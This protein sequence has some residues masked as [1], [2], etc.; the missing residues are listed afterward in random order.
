MN[1][2]SKSGKNNSVINDRFV[3]GSGVI[4]DGSVRMPDWFRLWA[5]EVREVA[6]V[7]SYRRGFQTV[8][9]GDRWW[10][11]M[12]LEYRDFLLLRD[13]G[14]IGELRQLLE[15]WDSVGVHLESFEDFTFRVAYAGVAL[16][17]SDGRMLKNIFKDV[18]LT[19]EQK[20]RALTEFG[21]IK[22]NHQ[23][24]S[25]LHLGLLKPVYPFKIDPGSRLFE[26]LAEYR[27]DSAQAIAEI[28]AGMGNFSL[29]VNRMLPKTTLLINETNIR[30]VNYIE[31]VLDASPEMF[32]QTNVEVV[33]GRKKST[34]MEGAGLD[35]VIIRNAFHHFSKKEKMLASIRM[36]MK[37]DGLLFIKDPVLELHGERICPESMAKTELIR[38]VEENGFRLVR[39][40]EF[41]EQ[42]LLKFEMV[43]PWPTP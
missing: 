37:P 43:N 38:I 18:E 25:L 19:E 31:K 8:G 9:G 11:T 23:I 33:F 1:K 22:R 4:N 5:N 7:R 20:N 12:P 42:V 27:L 29:V 14:S 39:Q 16:K 17:R 24:L 3:E 13:T 28:G 21:I 32:D 35:R 2:S 40:V 34:K 10:L 41:S 6:S 36:S 30:C 26:E 15:N